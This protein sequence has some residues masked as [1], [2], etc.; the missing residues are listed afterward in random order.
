M[1]DRADKVRRHAVGRSCIRRQSASGN[2][3]RGRECTREWGSKGRP[4]RGEEDVGESRRTGFDRRTP[5]KRL[6][7][8][9]I[10]DAQGIIGA[11]GGFSIENAVP[12]AKNSVLG[13]LPGYTNPWSK[14]V[15]VNVQR[16]CVKG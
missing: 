6:L 16:R 12:R 4:R 15:L 2:A 3:N 11:V 8:Y 5:V 7:E 14:V 10:L 13:E 9:A 1:R